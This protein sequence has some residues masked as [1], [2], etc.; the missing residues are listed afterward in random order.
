MS[1]IRY[2]LSV[3]G[4]PRLTEQDP[5]ATNSHKLQLVI[6]TLMHLI[7][8]V[9]LKDKT[10]NKQLRASTGLPSLNQAIVESTLMEA[11]K[12]IAYGL[13]SAQFLTPVQY[14]NQTRAK[15]NKVLSV[16][17]I[18]NKH[19]EWFAW[20]ATKLWNAS[21]TDLNKAET[22]AQAK[23]VIKNIAKEYMF[24]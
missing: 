11:W 7:E 9:N 2:A 1:K 3:F 18:R 10:L 16:P 6:N 22:L 8:G 24:E 17:K 14:K 20:K 4:R 5:E 12:A 13:P 15:C 19:R 21:I 23:S